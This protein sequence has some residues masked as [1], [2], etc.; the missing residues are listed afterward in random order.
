MLPFQK[1][2]EKVQ[3]RNEA[4]AKEMPISAELDML[5]STP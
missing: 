3:K 5:I 2:I 4:A 1:Y